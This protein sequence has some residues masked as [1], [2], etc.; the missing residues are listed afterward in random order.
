MSQLA[1]WL[2]DQSEI[3]VEA[4]SKRMMGSDILSNSAHLAGEEFFDALIMAS[5][6]D[7]FSE[8]RKVL[9]TWVRP[10]L[11][12]NTP[13]SQLPILMSIQSFL[14]RHIRATNTP[15][16]ALDILHESE[17]LM[18]QATLHLARL[19]MRYQVGKIHTEI[20]QLRRNTESLNK[21]K[22]DFISVAAHELKTPLTLIEGYAHMLKS[23]FP[24]GDY[25]RAAGMVNGI[26]N[27]TQRLREIIED[28][29]DTSVIEMQM[30]DI[31]LQP[32]WLDRILN[33]AVTEMGE[34]AS[35]RN[36][37]LSFNSEGLP[38]E[39]LLGDP[40]RLFQVFQKII[41]NAIKFTPDGGRINI[42][43]REAGGMAEVQI[44]DTGIGV[45]KA[46][47]EVIFEKFYSLGEVGL[48]SSSKSKFK[49][50]G[51]GLGLA[52]A[53]GIVEAHGG[54]IWVESEGYNEETPSGSCFHVALPI[55]HPN[56]P[57]ATVPPKETTADHN[58][59][60]TS[61]SANASN[62]PQ[63]PVFTYP[64]D[65]GEDHNDATTQQEL[66]S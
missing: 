12:Q 51:A 55:I 32:V 23:D 1:Q 16:A 20:S 28:M 60:D 49:G 6:K 35:E 59:A 42:T 40:E 47:Q 44:Q 48:H 19:E 56:T 37:E 3:V 43:G 41:E 33:I 58:K 62:P 14:N 34:I 39:S 27:G 26:M 21:H 15:Q 13:D 61:A 53:R 22:A 65:A 57:Q 30:I 4:F 29:I 18:M 31:N 11:S 46:D 45:N 52:I 2:R 9:E 7:E 54:R 17:S 50:G 8:V 10:T 36:I 24:S 5:D 63:Q 25:P 64:I 66:E 38:K